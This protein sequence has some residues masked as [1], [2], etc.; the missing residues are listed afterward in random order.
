MRRSFH[1]AVAV[2]ADE[3][4]ASINTTPLIDV[5]LVLLIMFI[6]TIP[7][8]LHE[9][10]MDLPQPAPL[11]GAPVTTHRLAIA[12]DG[13]V[14]LDG[15]VAAG[16][17]LAAGLATIRADRQASLVIASDAEARYERFVQVL[18]VVKRAGIT[19]LGFEGNARFAGG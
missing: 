1:S 19:R 10:P 9:V 13:S 14:T 16:A 5:M 18:A 8:M 2:A 12:A 11:P 3:P 15:R 17:A 4:I 6:I 7:P